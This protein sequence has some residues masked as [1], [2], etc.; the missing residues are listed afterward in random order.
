MV[1]CAAESLPP[2]PCISN[3][4]VKEELPWLPTEESNRATIV[5]IDY[6]AFDLT[7][8]TLTNVSDFGVVVDSR[9]ILTTSSQLNAGN[10]SVVLGSIKVRFI[11]GDRSKL[12]AMVVAKIHKGYRAVILTTR[13]DVRQKPVVFGEISYASPT[14]GYLFRADISGGRFVL[15]EASGASAGR[16]RSD[17]RS[18]CDARG[19]EPGA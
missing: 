13:E 18:I 14:S 3:N 15:R 11:S 7:S 8:H 12:P 6:Q 19:R 4:I 2:V 5:Q 9:T 10:L 16:E 17:S 1:G